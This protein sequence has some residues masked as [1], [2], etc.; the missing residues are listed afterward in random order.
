MKPPTMTAL[1]ELC[2]GTRDACATVTC[3]PRST[4]FAS[5]RS[6]SVSVRSSTSVAAALLLERDQVEDDQLLGI[7]QAGALGLAVQL[8]ELAVDRLDLAVLARQPLLERLRLHVDVLGDAGHDLVGEGIR[9]L[10][11]GVALPRAAHGDLDERVRVRTVRGGRARG[12]DLARRDAAAQGARLHA[13][14]VRDLLDHLVAADDLRHRGRVRRE[15]LGSARSRSARAAA[16]GRSWCARRRRRRRRARSG[17]RSPRRRRPRRGPATS[18]WRRC[19]RAARSRS[20]VPRR[21][22]VPGR[23]RRGVSRPAPRSF[24]RRLYQQGRLRHAGCPAGRRGPRGARNCA[25]SVTECHECVPDV[26]RLSQRGSRRPSPT[27]A[28]NGLTQNRRPTGGRRATSTHHA[29]GPS[30]D[31]CRSRARLRLDMA[32]RWAGAATVQLRRRP[33]RGGAPP[34]NRRRRR[35]QGSRAR[36][37]VGSGHVR[38]NRARR[39]PDGD[40]H[41]AGRLRRDARPSR[42]DRRGGACDGRRGRDRRGRSGLPATWSTPSRTSISGCGSPRIRRATWIPRSCFRRGSRRSRRVRRRRRSARPRAWSPRLRLRPSREPRGPWAAPSRSLTGAPESGRAGRARDGDHAAERARGSGSR[43]RGG[44]GRRPGGFGA[45]RWSGRAHR[46]RPAAGRLRSQETPPATP[47]PRERPPCRTRRPRRGVRATRARAH[48]PRG[49]RRATTTGSRRSRLVSRAGRRMPGT[50]G[51]PSPPWRPWRRRP[52]RSRRHLRRRPAA[53]TGSP[54]DVPDA[55]A[56][57]ATPPPTTGRPR[58][59]ARDRQRRGGPH[60]TLHETLRRR[61]GSARLGK[62]GA[63]GSRT[64]R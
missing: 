56:E 32:S 43:A 19:G 12:D 13:D 18:A 7:A 28:S 48:R 64:S 40:H 38:G 54:G 21:G 63:R 25:E 17:S 59:A 1:F 42:D 47:R 27:L 55:S 15:A 24:A 45:A 39:R 8:G 35:R 26:T 29:S 4:F 30:R 49:A 6:V 41:D 34:G 20:R 33:L 37:R 22:R 5:V 36:A 31:A 2:A 11:G 61:R 44:D 9:G 53:G 50:R 60:R 16:R 46:L 14:L 62:A 52:A 10:G 57:V 58:T 3:L 23:A 51:S